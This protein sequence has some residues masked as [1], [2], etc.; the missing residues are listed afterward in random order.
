MRLLRKL[1][2]QF[3]YCG[4]MLLVRIAVDIRKPSHA[5]PKRADM[6]AT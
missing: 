3:D 6:S 1:H 2:V 5:G 4:P